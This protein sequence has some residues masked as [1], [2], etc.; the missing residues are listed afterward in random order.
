MRTVSWFLVAVLVL[1][2]G[3]FLIGKTPSKQTA[4]T[5]METADVLMEP[6][7]A[8]MML[9]SIIIEHKAAPV[10]A[11]EAAVIYGVIDNNAMER[12]EDRTVYLAVVRAHRYMTIA[13]VGAKGDLPLKFPF[14]AGR[15]LNY[16]FDADRHLRSFV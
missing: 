1:A 3:I 2:L 8:E 5:H 15:D 11:S 10:T 12:R 13:G 4:A 9:T 14:L 7:L 16:V 6:L